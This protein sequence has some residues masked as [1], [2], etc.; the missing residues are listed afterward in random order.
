MIV[1]FNGIYKDHSDV[2]V[3]L[4]DRGFLLGDGVYE[5]MRT[6]NGKLFRYDD[7]ISRLG[8]SLEAIG[9]ILPANINFKNTI[10]DLIRLNN[11]EGSEISAYIQITRGAAPLRTHRFPQEDVNPTIFI[12]I[13]MLDNSKVSK[14]PGVKIITMDDIRWARCDIK[15]TSLLANV[16]A[17]QKAYEDGAYDAV[18][19]RNGTLLEGSHT[20]FFGIK[21]GV[22]FTAPLSNYILDSVTRRVVLELCGKLGITIKEE[23]VPADDIN[24]FDEFFIAG[25]TTEIK[26]VISINDETIGD[27]KPGKTTLEIIGEFQKHTEGRR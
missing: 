4:S 26:P 18:W 22:L 25:T 10:N 14:V 12:S 6:Y 24:G 16:L 17:N 9:I 15:T 19:I 20:S 2:S 5:V 23:A 11:I 8:K 3:S 13:N 1:Y 27:G 7:H 21:N